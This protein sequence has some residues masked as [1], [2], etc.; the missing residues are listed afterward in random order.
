MKKK[1]K[2]NKFKKY[3]ENASANKV[4]KNKII[5]QIVCISRVLWKIVAYWKVN[6]SKDLII[7]YF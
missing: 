1:E 2:H 4:D 3:S 6:I 7:I 5:Y